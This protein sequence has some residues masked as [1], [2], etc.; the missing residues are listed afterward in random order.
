MLN[1]RKFLNGIGTLGITTIVRPTKAQIIQFSGHPKPSFSQVTIDAFSGAS[2]GSWGVGPHGRMNDTPVPLNPPVTSTDPTFMNV[3]I[4]ATALLFSLSFQSSTH[5][6]D[7]PTPVTLT[8]DTGG[9]NQV[10]TSLGTFV[11]QGGT[12]A[13]CLFQFGLLNPTSGAKQLKIDWGNT[14]NL[15]EIYIVG[16]SF[17]NTKTSSLAN[18]FYGYN[19]ANDGGVQSAVNQVSSSTIIPLG[20]MAVS[21]H[22]ID[23]F[24]S[25]NDPALN[26][27]GTI[28][29]LDEGVTNNAYAQYFSGAGST[30]NARADNNVSGFW[31]SSIIGVRAA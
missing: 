21:M 19:T 6:A 13:T 2:N 24:G 31:C 7:D 22:M 9:T 12:T 1:R 18:C 25:W 29:D 30:I 3:G 10:M 5:G 20:D 26:A 15:Q 8:W 11:G 17:K 16:T 27:T 4:G 23:P 14:T 28:I